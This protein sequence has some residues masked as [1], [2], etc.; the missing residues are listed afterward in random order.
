MKLI[1]AEEARAL[2]GDKTIISKR[3]FIEE[4]ERLL[5]EIFTLINDSCNSLKYEC[6]VIISKDRIDYLESETLRIV[7]TDWGYRVNILPVYIASYA[8]EIDWNNKE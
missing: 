2:S 5:D 4:H 6:A 8:F 7:L 3:K 1:T